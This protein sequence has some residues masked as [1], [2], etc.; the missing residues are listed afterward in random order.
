MLKRADAIAAPHPTLERP[1]R[2]VRKRFDLSRR[3]VV[4]ILA[5]V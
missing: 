2:Y 4:S 5:V 3:Q 1:H